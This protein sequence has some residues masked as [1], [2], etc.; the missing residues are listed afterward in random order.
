MI[1]P[2]TVALAVVAVS[3]RRE[4]SAALKA[5]AKTA[6]AVGVC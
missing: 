6:H 1:P 4:P 2:T 5:N 3:A